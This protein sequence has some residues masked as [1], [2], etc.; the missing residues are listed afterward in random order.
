M[1]GVECAGSEEWQSRQ[2]AAV[3][4]N[5]RFCCRCVRSVD[6]ASHIPTSLLSSTSSWSTPNPQQCTKHTLALH[7][8]ATR[9]VV[10]ISAVV[11]FASI[12]SSLIEPL[13]IRL[14]LSR[15][16][17]D[18]STSR[19]NLLPQSNQ[20]TVVT[21]LSMSLIN[22][23]IKR[24]LRDTLMGAAHYG[25]AQYQPH[26]APL[27]LPNGQ[28]SLSTQTAAAAAAAAT[29]PQT[30]VSSSGVPQLATAS[31]TAALIAAANGSSNNATQATATSTSTAT[32]TATTTP[33]VANVLIDVLV[34][35]YSKY[36]MANKCTL[37][38][39]HLPIAECPQDELKI[40]C[41]LSN[42]T[43]CNQHIAKLYDVRESADRSTILAIQEFCEHGELFSYC[44]SDAWR[45]AI[46]P[47]Q[48]MRQLLRG[49]AALH[50]RAIAHRDLSLEN[51][52]LTRDL[53][54]RII[55]F[56]LA[57]EL[58]LDSA[59]A[60]QQST[61]AAGATGIQSQYID[62]RQVIGKL[63]YMSPEVFSRRRYSAYA[64]D[65]WQCGVIF[66]TMLTRRFPYQI[67]HASDEAF[68]LCCSGPQRLQQLVEQIL[69]RQAMQ[70]QLRKQEAMKE[71]ADPA[72]PSSS[73]AP[74]IDDTQMDTS[75]DAQSHENAMSDSTATTTSVPQHAL[76]PV[77]AELLSHLFCPE[78]QRWTCQQLLAHPY[79]AEQKQQQP[80][81]SQQPTQA[82][83]QAKTPVL[84]SKSPALTGASVPPRI[85]LPMSGVPR[86]S[87]P[88]STR[89]IVGTGSP[90]TKPAF[91]AP[92][93][94]PRQQM[95]Q[96]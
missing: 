23:C 60:V 77:E 20:I 52:L 89:G 92:Q 44:Q 74:T 47:K 2:S 41:R 68:A 62:D 4:F 31:A 65:M 79:F 83:Q 33:A 96:A 73:L 12:G 82:Q 67:P 7:N 51:L 48:Y 93:P 71:N 6:W 38:A 86:V 19:T 9:R 54:L 42:D 59:A 28:R 11:E 10:R 40:H 45:L 13:R 87:V 72:L 14:R 80:Q 5:R 81:Q 64:N 85:K 53:Q 55:D 50:A 61:L 57:V 25:T 1:I 27:Q 32:P 15:L 22:V 78:E 24:K 8:T 58:P 66:F 88:H 30:S 63:H 36:C 34:K 21:L 56:G 29:A 3:N 35:T 43:S 94:Q 69:P 26:N 17:F 84:Q 76:G 70:H 18:F 16:E 46:D 75:S 37:A 91:A 90:L 95:A 39:P 49:L